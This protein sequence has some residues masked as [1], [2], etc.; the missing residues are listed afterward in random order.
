VVVGNKVDLLVQ[1]SP[2]FLQ[3][4]EK[5]V[6]ESLLDAGIPEFNVKHVSLISAKSGFGVENLITQ[7]HAKWQNQGMLISTFLIIILTICGEASVTILISL[8]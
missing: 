3:N 1:D 5:S 8:H 6:R 2:D 4:I 7:I